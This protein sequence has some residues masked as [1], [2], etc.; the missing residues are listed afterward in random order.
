MIIHTN[1][2]KASA[3]PNKNSSKTTQYK[4]SLV[5]AVV[6][7]NMNEVARKDS[8]KHTH[9]VISQRSPVFQIFQKFLR[10]RERERE[11]DGQIGVSS[12][13]VPIRGTCIF[14][15]WTFC[16]YGL[17]SISQTQSM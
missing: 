6:C 5:A 14:T 8:L 4:S 2:N 7:F 13:Y 9:N 15:L 10:E 3:P 11:R 17:C 12:M 16:L 1:K